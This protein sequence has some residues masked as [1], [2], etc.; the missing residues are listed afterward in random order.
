MWQA[1]H[2]HIRIHVVVRVAVC[3]GVC[4]EHETRDERDTNNT[5]NRANQLGRRTIVVLCLD[6][7]F[8]F[9]HVDGVVD[10]FVG[11][12]T[13]NNVRRERKLGAVAAQLVWQHVK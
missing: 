7:V 13:R 4:K 5:K 11:L 6:Q 10:G 3:A 8:D 1:A 12:R 9:D 2:R